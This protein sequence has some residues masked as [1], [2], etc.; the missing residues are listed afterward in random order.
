MPVFLTWSVGCCSFWL[1]NFLGQTA[2]NR[3]LEWFWLLVFWSRAKVVRKQAKKIADKFFLR[4][5][6]QKISPPIKESG[7]GSN[8]TNETA[9]FNQWRKPPPSPNTFFFL[10]LFIFNRLDPGSH[11]TFRSGLTKIFL[12]LECFSFAVFIKLNLLYCCFRCRH[13][14]FWPNVGIWF[15]LKV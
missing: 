3:H 9:I 6:L 7:R 5:G 11:F 10:P 8:L 14:A 4:Q 12:I 13:C 1:P 2:Q 15:C